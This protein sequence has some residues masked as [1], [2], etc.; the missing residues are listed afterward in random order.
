AVGL[1]RAIDL[2][3][4]AGAL[5]L[6]PV[7]GGVGVVERGVGRLLPAPRSVVGEGDADAGADRELLV[8][9]EDG[10]SQGEQEP[11]GNGLGL[12]VVGDL[13]ADDDELVTAEAGEEVL[14]TDG[15]A[16]AFGSSGEEVVAGGVAVVFV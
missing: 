1:H 16:Q 15:D 14:T 12:A 9:D 5:A 8:L 6:G 2:G 4:P 10:M 3:V 11:L 13:V 7:H